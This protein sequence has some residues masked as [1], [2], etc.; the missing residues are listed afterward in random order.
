MYM[1]TGAQI[2]ISHFRYRRQ[3]HGFPIHA[4]EEEILK[5]KKIH[6][7]ITGC[8]KCHSVK[9]IF[10]SHDKFGISICGSHFETGLSQIANTD[11]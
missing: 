5:G 10:K 3:R 2:L 8:Q 7:I 11:M 4:E 1:L 6:G 9:P